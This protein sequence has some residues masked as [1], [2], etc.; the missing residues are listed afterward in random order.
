M[1]IKAIIKLCIYSYK[2]EIGSDWKVTH[3]IYHIFTATIV[4]NIT[5]K[6]MLIC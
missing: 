6:I 1:L 2:F 5:S 4:L 3:I